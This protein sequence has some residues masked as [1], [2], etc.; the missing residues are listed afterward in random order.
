MNI[1]D[2]IRLTFLYCKETGTVSRNG[3]RVCTRNSKGYLV[4]KIYGKQIRLHRIA[5]FLHSGTWPSMDID[6][7]NGNR[8]DNR[9]ANLRLASAE[10]N[11]HNKHKPRQDSSSSRIGVTW[12]EKTKKWRARITSNK[13]Q[14]HI[15]YFDTIEEASDAYQK[16]K[17]LRHKIVSA[18]TAST[19]VKS[20]A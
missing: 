16:A 15:G 10:E 8:C 17:A 7:I 13:K 3:K 9:I 20:T 2:K 5:W 14:F 19:L 12:F 6:H 4:T 18:S 11:N 1:E